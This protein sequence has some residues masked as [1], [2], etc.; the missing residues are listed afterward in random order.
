M[1]KADLIIYNPDLI[2]AIES[3]E[4]VELSPAYTGSVEKTNGRYNGEAY[5]YLQSIG[6][7]NHLAVVERGRSGSDLR[8]TICKR[9]LTLIEAKLIGFASY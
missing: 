7:I 9:P 5:A 1:L 3:G 2:K 6:C 4:I 8:I